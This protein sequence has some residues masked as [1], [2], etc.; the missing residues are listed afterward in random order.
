MSRC[1]INRWGPG[2]TCERPQNTEAVKEMKAKLEAMQK[3]RAKQDQIWNQ[4]EPEVKSEVKS[5]LNT[6]SLT[7]TSS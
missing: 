6:K 5:Q 4:P 1:N 7:Y 2:T 3:E